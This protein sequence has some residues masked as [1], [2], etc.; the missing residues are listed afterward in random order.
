MFHI[1]CLSHIINLCVQ[2]G[3]K[4]NNNFHTKL[5]N[6]LSFTRASFPRKHTF[7]TVCL[8]RNLKPNVLPQNVKTYLNLIYYMLRGYLPYK[9]IIT[10][11]SDMEL[12]CII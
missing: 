3:Q 8:D 4:V 2:Y 9:D 6:I 10:L 12:P 1:R 5:R 7:K 11:F